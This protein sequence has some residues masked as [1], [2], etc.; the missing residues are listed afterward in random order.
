MKS[1]RVLQEARL[2]DVFG[3]ID[4]EIRVAIQ[5]VAVGL[6]ALALEKSLAWAW[7]AARAGAVEPE[8]ASTRWGGGGSWWSRREER[9]ASR[10]K[11]SQAEQSKSQQSVNSGSRL[12]NGFRGPP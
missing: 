11:Q 4:P 2:W 9:R 8:Q 7:F 1:S 5:G 10:T 6:R 3:W 12:R